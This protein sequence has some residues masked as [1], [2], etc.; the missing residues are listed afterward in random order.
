[1][2]PLPWLISVLVISVSACVRDRDQTVGSA[3]AKTGIQQAEPS[4][5]KASVA[6][7]VTESAGTLPFPLDCTGMPKQGGLL[8][9]QTVPGANVSIGG[10]GT[11]A[12]SSGYFTVGFDR[13]AP[14]KETVI[15][16]TVGQ[17]RSMEIKILPREYGI[18]SIDNLP[19]S[20]VSTFTGKQR[21]RIEASTV[22]KTAGFASR[23]AETGFRD[24][25]TFPLDDIRKTSP[26]GAQRIL[27]GEL[28]RPHYGVDLA[29]P[30]GTPVYA[31]ADGIVSLADDD[32]YFEGQTVFID[33]GQGLISMYLHMSTIKVETGQAVKR[34]DVLGKVGATGRATGP[35]LCWRLKWR[36][37]NLDPELLT[38]WPD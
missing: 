22:R 18:S 5:I 23:V 27:N 3:L 34:G 16:E 8:A 9:C 38:E 17:T 4:V 14:K 19:P 6:G 29:A 21:T 36:N 25:F 37:R 31:P 1:M 20:Q 10:V 28:Q 24:G 35:H 30:A 26:F 2:R 13:D 33:H 32:L 12:D 15:V 11:I 7:V